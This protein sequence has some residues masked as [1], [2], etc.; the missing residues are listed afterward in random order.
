MVT[1]GKHML[2]TTYSPAHPDNLTLPQPC[3]DCLE[4]WQLLMVVAA[5]G[6][7]SRADCCW[8][9]VGKQQHQIRIKKLISN[10]CLVAIAR[11]L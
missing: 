5:P 11:E 3:G 8:P 9:Q 10:I 1:H 4:S 7:I 6:Q 2:K